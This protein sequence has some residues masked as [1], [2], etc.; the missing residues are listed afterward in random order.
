LTPK[1]KRARSTTI[2][3]TRKRAR[4][5]DKK[6]RETS[7]SI[8]KNA[9]KRLRRSV[10]VIG[11]FADLRMIDV[12]KCLKARPEGCRTD[13]ESKILQEKNFSL[14]TR[15]RQVVARQASISDRI[16]YRRF[17]TGAR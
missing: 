14:G 9:E 4:V 1:S 10:F 7:A 3:A 2:E 5:D 8:S 13:S 15:L 11:D 6:R 12:A 16:E 17:A